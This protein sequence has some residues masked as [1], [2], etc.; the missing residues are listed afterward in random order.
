MKRYI[1]FIDGVC[2]L[3]NGLVK[4]INRF[5]NKN[6]FVFSSL[7]GET[8]SFLNQKLML[9]NNLD[10]IILYSE[11]EQKSFTEGKAVEIILKNLKYFKI[12]G[13]LISLIP[14]FLKNFFYK[15]IAKNRYKIF[16]KV[17]YCEFEKNINKEKI[18]R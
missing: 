16:G 4:F 8:F 7:Q 6:I 5:D 18:L 13:Y 10:Y 15:I 11:H 9:S 12:I 1:V 17:D 2:S 3:C 14:L